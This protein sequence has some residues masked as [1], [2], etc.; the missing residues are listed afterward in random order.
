[1][2]SIDDVVYG[3]VPDPA[4]ALMQL[5]EDSLEEFSEC[6]VS[7]LQVEAIFSPI[8]SEEGEG[9]WS[10]VTLPPRDSNSS[11]SS[12]SPTHETKLVAT[13]PPRR[14]L[15]SEAPPQ[16]PSTQKRHYR[17][18]AC[19]HPAPWTAEE[20]AIFLTGLAQLSCDRS[21]TGSVGLGPGVARM[22]AEMIGSRTAAQVRSHAQKH[23]QRLARLR[24]D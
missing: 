6:R 15:S 8:K 19:G 16:C 5:E 20:Q 22:L 24:A 3:I 17:K 10:T 18:R 9:E 4:S 21:H 13:Q 1:M 23:F 12:S 11:S 2:L 14:S 7:D